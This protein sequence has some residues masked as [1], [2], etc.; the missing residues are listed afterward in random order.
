MAPDSEDKDTPKVNP[1]VSRGADSGDRDEIGPRQ[2]RWAE[3]R[4]KT[5]VAVALD[6]KQ[7]DGRVDPKG[8]A[9]GRRERARGGGGADPADR[10]RQGHPGPRGRGPGADPGDARC[11]QHHPG[12]ALSAVAEILSYLYRLNGKAMDGDVTPEIHAG[13]DETGDRR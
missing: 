7:P 6:Y 9:P 13:T 12:D 10:L 8:A 2:P 11:G 4:P 3:P 5:T 1:G